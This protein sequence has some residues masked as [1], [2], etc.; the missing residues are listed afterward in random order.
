MAESDSGLVLLDQHAAHE[1]ILF[2]KLLA[3]LRHQAHRSQP[4]LIPVTLELSAS[5]ATLLERAREQLIKLGFEIEAFGGTTVLVRALPASF[6]QENVAGM[7][8]DIIDE[9]R[10]TGAMLSRPDEIALAQTACRHAV[11]GFCEQELC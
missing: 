4:L 1:R 9:L 7:V 10:D 6:P 5:E 2:E 11:P 8:R 3:T